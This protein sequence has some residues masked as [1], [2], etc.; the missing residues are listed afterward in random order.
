[1]IKAIVSGA[2]G[3][4]GKRIINAL[5][6]TEGIELGAALEVPGNPVLG[7]DAGELAGIGKTGIKLTASIE[8]AL[9]AGNVIIDF[10]SP[11]ATIQHLLAAAKAGVAMV[12]GTTGLSP[13]D[14]ARVQE[15]GQKIPCVMAPN[16]SVGI[17][18]L[19]NILPQMARVL[20]DYD[21]EIVEAHHRHKKDAPSGTAL[22]LAQVLA[23]A[24]DSDLDEVG[25]YGRYGLS[26]ERPTEQIGVHAV[27]GG[28]IVGVHTVLFAG[29]G[30]SLEVTH[31]AHSRDTF[32]QGAVRAAKFA[33]N[34]P[35]GLYDMQDVL[36]LKKG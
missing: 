29:P 34:A 30:E 16:M 1:M 2:A 33:A 4:M 18:L 12:I 9:A 28:D 7:Q 23:Q 5:S 14:I 3:R 8:E 11:T 35:L 26:G 24:K 25:V 36:G 20:R 15:A 19:L 13:E 31:R 32:A 22:K 6:Q 17:N 21:I 27:R 10:S